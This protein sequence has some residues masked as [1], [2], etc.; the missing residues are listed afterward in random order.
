ASGQ[1]V[2][3]RRRRKLRWI[4][5]AGLNR[6]RQL[7]GGHRSCRSARQRRRCW[8]TRVDARKA[9]ALASRQ[10]KRQDRTRQNAARSQI[11][12]FPPSERNAPPQMLGQSP[13]LVRIMAIFRRIQRI[14]LRNGSSPV[15]G[16]RS[17]G[18]AW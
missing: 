11:H 10:G 5:G 6:R 4:G 15:R 7:A 2:A 13:S 17:T 1:L 16:G 9:L 12:Q 8:T 14:W 3:A 18:G